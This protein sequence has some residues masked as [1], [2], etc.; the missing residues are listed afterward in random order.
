MLWKIKLHKRIAIKLRLNQ[1]AR[2][3][4][5]MQALIAIS[6]IKL[7][8][9]KKYNTKKEKGEEKEYIMA[10]KPLRYCNRVK[11]PNRSDL[12]NLPQLQ[13]PEAMMFSS[14]RKRTK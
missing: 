1:I 3:V 5:A 6:H 2:F 12:C 7:P 11:L 8:F 10:L 4:Y 14:G 13:F 9:P